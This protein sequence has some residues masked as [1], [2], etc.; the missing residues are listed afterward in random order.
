[1][2][3]PLIEFTGLQNVLPLSVHLQ[4]LCRTVT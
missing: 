2:T 4:Q 1:M 3:L